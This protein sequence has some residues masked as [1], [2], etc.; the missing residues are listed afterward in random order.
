MTE[1]LSCGN[2]GRILCESQ[3]VNS[4]WPN[5][6]I[7]WQ[8]TGS[9][10]AQVMACCLTAPSHYLNQCW[11][12]ISTVHWHSFEYNLTRDTS[13]INEQNWL[14]NYFPKIS[15]KSPRGQWDKVQIPEL[16]WPCAVN[17]ISSMQKMESV[18][19][20]ILTPLSWSTLHLLQWLLSPCM[21]SCHDY[22]ISSGCWQSMMKSLL[23]REGANW[24]GNGSKLSKV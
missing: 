10:L 23:W 21:V 4:L 7:W 24:L 16:W 6:V 13:A 2:T 9:T 22:I 17:L 11:F 3:W 18:R 1:Q 12:T 5:N 8:K 20:Q 19:S 15:L 14:E